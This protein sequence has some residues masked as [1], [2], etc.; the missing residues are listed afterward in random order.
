MVPHVVFT[1][2]G[3]KHF[4]QLLT[5]LFTSLSPFF[6]FLGA[7]SLLVSVSDCLCP[8][9]PL[10]VSLL[11]VPRPVAPL[12]P[13]PEGSGGLALRLSHR[14]KPVSGPERWLAILEL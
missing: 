3:V 10:S 8:V 13:G 6:P 9:V 1:G 5:L 11:L 12:P 7:A 14:S 4:L 2:R